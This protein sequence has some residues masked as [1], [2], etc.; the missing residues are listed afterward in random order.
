MLGRSCCQTMLHTITHSSMQPIIVPAEVLLVSVMDTRVLFIL[1]CQ[2]QRERRQQ[3]SAEI[4][5]TFSQ[6]VSSCEKNTNMKAFVL[7]A[8]LCYMYAAAAGEEVKEHSVT[9]DPDDKFN[10]TWSFMG[11][12]PEDE[13]TF[14]VSFYS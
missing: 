11:V 3:S 10:V 13:I 12:E 7:A 4:V 14:T 9:L 1:S 2:L 6:I 8:F 5:L